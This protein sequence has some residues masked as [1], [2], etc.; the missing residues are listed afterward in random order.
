MFKREKLREIRKRRK[1]NKYYSVLRK[2]CKFILWFLKGFWY[3]FQRLFL[4]A[5]ILLLFIWFAWWSSQTPSLYREWTDTEVILSE[6]TFSWNIIDIK[7]VRN[8]NHISDKESIPGYYDES[9]DLEK[10]ESLYY[11]IEPF[12]EYDGPAHTM[13]SFGF[14]DWKYVSVSAELR[15]EKWESFDPFLWLMNQYEI[16]YIVWDENDLIK[17]RANI[18]KD[19]VRLYPMDVSKQQIT[20]LFSSVLHRAD[21]LTKEP[22]FY[23]TFW[24]TCTTSILKHVN[25]L[26]DNKISWFDMKILLPSNSDKIA[27]DLWL[28]DTD[29]ILEHAREYYI[30][31]SL[32]EIY[33]FDE[34]YSKLIRKERK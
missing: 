11:I 3:I 19:T 15:K 16:V 12:S 26:R 23:N 17:L 34:N 20:D 9:Y 24:N 25:S 31:N 1:Y 32:S 8:F 30:I 5:F 2:I 10:I 4:L 18:R 21:K 7:N 22:E 27:Y 6:I 13:L 29:F 14:S 28:I 33:W